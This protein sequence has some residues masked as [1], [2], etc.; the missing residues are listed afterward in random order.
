MNKW[1]WIPTTVAL[2]FVGD[3]LA[4]YAL[5][6][7]AAESD[8]RYS[9]LYSQRAGADILLVGNS[10]G[11]T[12][13]QPVLEALTG[14]STFNLSYNGIPVKIAHVLA[15]DYLDRYGAPETMLVDV[16]MLDM[17]NVSLIQDFRVYA[18]YSEGLDG[19]LRDSFPN[20]W[21]GTRLAH[22][23]R[24]G[25]EVAQ[26]MLYY[27]D[28]SDETWLLDR[29]MPE[30]L[31][32]TAED[33]TTNRN[34]YTPA[35]IAL[36]ADMVGRFEDAGTDVHLTINPY[37]PSY[38]RSLDNL[39]TLAA[40]ITAATGLPVYDYS[41]AVEAREYFGDYQHLNVA[42]AEVF[43]ERLVADLKLSR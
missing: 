22:L 26:R 28:Q 34:G 15:G 7:I 40:D 2:F 3:R 21:G 23:S 30:R 42:G 17:D 9:R 32:E 37:F 19:L 35:R 14:K 36:L 5:S 4:A 6:K 8:F 39:D 20:I 29:V 10:R 27:A 38:A 1:L 11:L 43:L 33:L 16:T 12:F 31:T 13:Y 41:D 18:P 25:G 24:Y